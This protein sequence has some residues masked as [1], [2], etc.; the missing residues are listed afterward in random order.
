M[1]GVRISSSLLRPRGALAWGGRGFGIFSRANRKTPR[2]VE[3]D[4][5]KVGAKERHHHHLRR[6]FHQLRPQYRRQQTPGHDPGNRLGAEFLGRGIGG[7]EAV[8]AL[9]RHVD[10]GEQ[11]AQQKQREGRGQQRVGA[12]RPADRAADGSHHEPRPSPMALHQCRQWR[13]GQHR[14]D[15][16]QR[17]RQGCPADIRGQ[18]LPGEARD[19]EDHRHLRAEDGLG[20]DQHPD[21]AA[22]AGVIG[23]GLGGKGGALGHPP[24]VNRRSA[25]AKGQRENFLPSARI[26]GPM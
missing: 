5:R 18:R 21:R 20:G 8:K 14:A 2:Q 24:S 17:D 10:A 6:R 22:G 1:R 19:D 23:R 9:R 13:G 16:D 26:F 11:R 4:H 12:D 7:G 3:R 25:C 15:H